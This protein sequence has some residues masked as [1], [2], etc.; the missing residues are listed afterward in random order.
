M[1]DLPP[2]PLPYERVYARLCVPA[3]VSMICGIVAIPLDFVFCLG[4]IPAVAAIVLGVVALRMFRSGRP[5]YGKPMAIVGLITGGI[6]LLLAI[7]CGALVFG[8]SLMSK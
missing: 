8:S 2:P 6:A 7:G 4:G 5:L 1:T 3:L